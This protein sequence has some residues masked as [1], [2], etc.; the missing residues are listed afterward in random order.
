MIRLG[1]KRSVAEKTVFDAVLIVILASA[2]ARTINGSTPFFPTLGSGFVLVLVHRFFAWIACHSHT[3]GI[4]INGEPH[5]IV[6]NGD[7]QLKAMRQNDISIHDLEEDLRLSAKA[8]HLS[9]IR[10]TRVERSGDISFIMAA[11]SANE[12]RS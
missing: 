10:V 3:F 5:V 9:K 1:S 2:L 11:T 4:L 6:R 7:V 8:E 12:R